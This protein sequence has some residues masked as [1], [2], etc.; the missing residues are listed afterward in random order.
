MLRT[1]NK[2]L[3]Y[4]EADDK[5]K[6][7]PIIFEEFANLVDSELSG[8][9]SSGSS[10]GG[11]TQSTPLSEVEFSF[12]GGYLQFSSSKEYKETFHLTYKKTWPTPPKILCVPMSRAKN[13]HFAVP[14]G[15]K[16]VSRSTT[17]SQ[18]EVTWG[19]DYIDN[20][21]LAIVF[22]LVVPE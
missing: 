3:P 19:T 5:V 22:F 11:S 21:G 20:Y 7:F 1:A 18:I 8:S 10:T 16:M 12:D 4:P 15:Y 6:D 13:D 2:Q 9:S 17:D 14:T